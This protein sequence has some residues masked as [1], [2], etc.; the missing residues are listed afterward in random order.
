MMHDKFTVVALR[1][2]DDGKRTLKS[3]HHTFF[4]PGTWP[5]WRRRNQH[6]NFHFALGGSAPKTPVIDML[7]ASLK[8]IDISMNLLT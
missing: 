2:K 4:E 1:L 5:K 3:P 6:S 7:E 8:G